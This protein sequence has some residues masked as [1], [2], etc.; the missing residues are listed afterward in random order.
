MVCQ[1]GPTGNTAAAG[2]IQQKFLVGVQ[3]QG[4][5]ATAIM[6]FTR[7][8]ALVVLGAVLGAVPAES[9]MLPPLPP[10]VIRATVCAF[11][12]RG[13]SRTAPLRTSHRDMCRLSMSL[14]DELAGV[15]GMKIREIKQELAER[16]LATDD[17]FEKDEFV[18]RLAQAR[19]E[20]PSPTSAP[21]SAPS[22]TGSSS[23]A[24]TRA[25]SSQQDRDSVVRAEVEVMRVAEIRAELSQRAV[26]SHGLFEKSEFVELLVKARLAAP[27]DGDSNKGTSRAATN[28]EYKDVQTKKMDNKKQEPQT[29]STAGGSRGGG[30]GGMGGNPFGGMPGACVRLSKAVRQGLDTASGV[31]GGESPSGTFD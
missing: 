13:A 30:G 12:P 14:D 31:C 10:T 1:L 21:T 6:F 20:K 18:T 7:T 17:I 3:L 8:R 22:G 5:R 9:F 29:T 28:P 26:S 24:T 23:S 19:V 11:V 15:R 2:N 16:G 4:S 25:E 27:G